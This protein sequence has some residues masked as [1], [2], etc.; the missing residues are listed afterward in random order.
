[1]NQL[2]KIV[3]LLL[4]AVFL[5]ISLIG[6]S[7]TSASS[8]SKLHAKTIIEQ[9]EK[10]LADEDRE[11]TISLD[12]SK[13]DAKEIEPNSSLP[14][15]NKLNTTNN[16]DQNTS[17]PMIESKQEQKSAAI[18]SKVTKTTSK[19]ENK[20]PLN[21]TSNKDE[22]QS[23]TQTATTRPVE[24]T[25]QAESPKQLDTVSITITGPKDF[26][27]ILPKINVRF[28]EGD[29]VLDVLL[30]VAKKKNFFV[31][32]NGSGAMAYIEGIDNLYEFDYGP[33]SG[34]NFKLNGAIVS[35]SSDLVKIKKDDRI[36]WVYSEDF[37]EGDE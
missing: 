37:T 10:I 19:P 31:E 22:T 28:S 34:W 9:D 16:N 12:G 20:P 8:E 4:F 27:V 15:N 26:G 24:V 21:N 3:H 14:D 30:K 1:M 11:E 32:Y 35:K 13:L 6:C 2:M 17:P 23:K 7:S 36:E 5:I 18:E 33:N 25:T 29:T